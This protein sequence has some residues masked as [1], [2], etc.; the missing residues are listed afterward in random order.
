MQT[1]DVKVVVVS[2]KGTGWLPE[3]GELKAVKRTDWD[4]G[5]IVTYQITDGK[6]GEN[7]ILPEDQV[8][9]VI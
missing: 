9:E 5:G 1:E 2:T 3:M 4:E 8:R 7:T 6:A